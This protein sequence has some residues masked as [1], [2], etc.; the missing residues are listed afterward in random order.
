MTVPSRRIVLVAFLSL[1]LAGV[2]GSATARQ[3]KE[4]PR[5]LFGDDIAFRIDSVGEN[6]IRRG[7]LMVRVA[8]TW[9]DA[10]LTPKLRLRPAR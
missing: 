7:T 2:L 1:L 10:E 6:G 8:G 3:A 9:V 5:I 4:E